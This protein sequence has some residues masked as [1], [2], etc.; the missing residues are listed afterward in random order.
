MTSQLNP[1][2]D[3]HDPKTLAPMDQAFVAARHM[4]KDEGMRSVGGPL[5]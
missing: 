1:R 2:S 5:R 4:L 3:M